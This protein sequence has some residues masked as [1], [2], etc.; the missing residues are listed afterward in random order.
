MSQGSESEIHS[1]DNQA[2][3]EKNFPN[4]V[5]VRDDREPIRFDSADGKFVLDD[6]ADVTW[7]DGDSKEFTQRDLRTRIE[8]WLT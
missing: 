5:K 1:D 2:V 6:F 7:T 4:I 3:S 8:P